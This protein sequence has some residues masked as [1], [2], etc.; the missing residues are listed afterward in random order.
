[1]AFELLSIHAL[2]LYEIEIA[3]LTQTVAKGWLGHLA[4]MV[5]MQVWLR[6]RLR[7]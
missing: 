2:V 7:L 5:L 3:N 6:L 4:M 1:M